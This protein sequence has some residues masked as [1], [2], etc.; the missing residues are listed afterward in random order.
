MVRIDSYLFHFACFR[1]QR[2]FKRALVDAEFTKVCPRC[3]GQA[4]R[5]GR[6]FKAPRKDDRAQWEKVRF[7]VAHGFL[8]QHVY[9]SPRGGE[10]I[11]YPTNLD[12]ARQFVLRFRAQAWSAAL[13][14]VHAALSTAELTSLSR[15][16]PGRLTARRQSVPSLRIS[17]SATPPFLTLRGA[18]HGG[19]RWE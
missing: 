4:I 7:L 5:V 16:A 8:F 11:P 12:D 9:A 10:Q 13:P 6:H 19:G 15:T 14:E 3:R 18:R 2:S 1:C 17:Q